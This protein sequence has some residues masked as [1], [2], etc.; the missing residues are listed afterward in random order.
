MM[1]RKWSFTQGL[2]WVCWCTVF[3]G[4]CSFKREH[5]VIYS[6][7]FQSVT[8]SGFHYILQCHKTAAGYYSLDSKHCPW[9]ASF[10]MKRAFGQSSRVGC[11]IF[12]LSQNLWQCPTECTN[13]EDRG[14][15][16]QFMTFEPWSFV[17]VVLCFESGLFSAFIHPFLLRFPIKL[18]G[19]A[20][21]ANYLGF[22]KQLQ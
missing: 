22:N 20:V 1:C 10:T 17:A 3:T 16:W 9:Y 8:P 15:G 2:S 21:P 19:F 18:Q 13:Q 5:G 12:S 7:R 4:K 14:W 6:S 11:I